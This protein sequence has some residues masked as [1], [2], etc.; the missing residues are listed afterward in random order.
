[1]KYTSF[2]SVACCVAG[3]LL[4]GNDVAMA[5]LHPSRPKTG[6]VTTVFGTNAPSVEIYNIFINNAP[7]AFNVAGAPRF[8][9]EGKNKQFYLGVGGY[10]KTTGS[11]DWGN[12]ITSATNFTTSSIP[13]HPIKGNGGL[14]QFSAATS[15]LFANFVAMPGS[16]HQV[17]VYISANFLGEGYGLDLQFAY[18]KYRGI[19]AGYNYTLFCDVAAAP[20][21]I[22]YEN[23]PGLT[24]VP[25]A[26]IDYE[27]VI[28]P[29]WSVA[30]GAELPITSITP[31]NYTYA[32]NQRIPD[33]PAY[34]QYNWDKGNSWLRLSA[35]MRN[36]QYRDVV[37]NKNQ[38]ATGWGVK[39]SGSAAIT[40]KLTTFYQAAYGKGISSYFQDT[41]GLNLDLVP[42]QSQNGK[43]S[44]SKAWGGYFTLQYTFSP[45]V[46]ASTT[47]SQIR[48]YTPEY[49]TKNATPW[50]TQYKYAQY[51]VSNVFW[52]I[53]PY[54]QTG[55]EYL[56]GR[57]VNMD[58]LSRHNNRL[59][60]M[61]QLS[62]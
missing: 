29:T 35:I 30:I 57:R 25:N 20:A 11:F 38:N 43:L 60:A 7:K 1:M 4:I 55:V 32:V 46:F 47:F 58:E 36:M 39:A 15:N 42:D 17:G 16:K 40:K 41:Y 2:L 44:T 6:E 27:Y 51:V 13:M 24:I 12:P 33:I 8:A 9:I 50:G 52:N 10:V 26:V 37:A 31:D 61:L 45:K 54:L 18:M 19:T 3:F 22:D 14:L 49:N 48:N 62:F 21:T 53:T 23:A 28:N 59:Q 5:Q 56:W 34:V